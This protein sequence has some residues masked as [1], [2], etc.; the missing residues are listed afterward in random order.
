MC[1]REPVS[2]SVCVCER[3]C[4]LYVSQKRCVSVFVCGRERVCVREWLKLT[5]ILRPELQCFSCEKGLMVLSRQVHV[6]VRQWFFSR[7]PCV[8][9]S[10]KK[11]NYEKLYQCIFFFNSGKICSSYHIFGIFLH[12]LY[13]A[14]RK[15]FKGFL[16]TLHSTKRNASISLVGLVLQM[17]QVK[18]ASV[19]YLTRWV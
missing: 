6:V 17:F 3:V 11:S 14:P 1:G 7:H 5:R 15:R 13:S 9:E 10:R 4:V 16:Q 8:P 12:L 18:R 19:C 2:V